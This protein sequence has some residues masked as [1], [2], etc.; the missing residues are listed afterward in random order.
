MSQVSNVVFKFFGINLFEDRLDFLDFLFDELDLLDLLGD[1]FLMIG[2]SS[3]SSRIQLRQMPSAPPY[4]VSVIMM[5][6]HIQY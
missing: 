3:I 2:D 6:F 1:S 5:L 4:I